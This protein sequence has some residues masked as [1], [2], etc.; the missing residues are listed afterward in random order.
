MR[1]DL[2]WLG[3]DW[4]R[5]ERRQSEFFGDYRAVLEGLRARKLV[6]LCFCT[7]GAVAAQDR[8]QAG[9]AARPR[10]CPALSRPLP[11]AAASASRGEY[12]GGER[13]ALRLDMGRALAE[14]EA[15]LAYREF[16]EGDAPGEMVA[17]PDLWGDAVIGRRDV[18]ASY[19]LACV[20]DDCVQGVTDV[21][22][23]ADLEAPPA[24]HVLLQRLLG[25]RTPDYRHHR[26][27]LDEDGTKLAKSKG[28]SHAPGF[29]RGGRER[30]GY[31]GDAV[32]ADGFRGLDGF[33][34]TASRVFRARRQGKP[35]YE[36]KISLLPPPTSPTCTS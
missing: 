28:A 31:R 20:H 22:R 5:P 25:F 8:R 11:R 16:F 35:H 30:G 36:I 32:G 6:I 12:R 10:R 18:S 29:S 19:H 13:F 15:P 1:E 4:P 17:R 7:R 9:L 26:L 27:V 14:V 24:L 2:A 21:V 23:G 33:R 3:L 34:K